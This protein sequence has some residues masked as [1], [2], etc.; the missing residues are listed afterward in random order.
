M[1]KTIWLTL[2][3]TELPQIITLSSGDRVFYLPKGVTTTEGVKRSST[4]SY[5]VRS[6]FGETLEITNLSNFCKTLFG[7]T[8]NKRARLVSSFSEL[9]SNIRK[10][11]SV[12]GWT[13]AED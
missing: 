6:P 9:C 2:S 13:K 4:T 3:N 7:T 12:E 1:S 11:E 8:E 10:E 5:K